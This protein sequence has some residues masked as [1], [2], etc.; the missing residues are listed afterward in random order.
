MKFVENIDAIVKH[1]G[2]QHPGII[3][4]LSQVEWDSPE[5]REGFLRLLSGRMQ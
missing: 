2:A 4:N 3:M 1:L 5:D